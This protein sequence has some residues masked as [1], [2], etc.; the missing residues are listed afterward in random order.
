M[1]PERYPA[2][3]ETDT[4]HSLARLVA[5]YLRDDK[6]ECLPSNHGDLFLTPVYPSYVSP[7]PSTC[8]QLYT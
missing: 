8:V 1:E 4:L 5:A 2:S 3:S 6:E 7:Y